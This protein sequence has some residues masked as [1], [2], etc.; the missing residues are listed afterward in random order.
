MKTAA[1]SVSER[2][3]VKIWRSFLIVL[4]SPFV[5]LALEFF[6]KSAWPQPPPNFSRIL[7]TEQ[8][9]HKIL[10]PQA[11][12][13]NY[14]REF[15]V[16]I[17]ANQYGY[18]QGTWPGKPIPGKVVWLFGDSFTF[19]WGVE[20]QETFSARLNQAGFS[21]YDLGIPDDGWADYEYRFEWAKTHLP[22]PDLIVIASYDNDYAYLAKTIFK[23]DAAKK[24]IKVR[25]ILVK[26]Q[27]GRLLKRIS[28]HLGLTK[29]F[30]MYG[31]S[32]I[33]VRTAY[34]RDFSVHEK[35]YLDSKSGQITLFWV[36]HFIEEAKKISSN[37]ILVRIAPGYCN[38]LSW[39]KE[40]LSAL[41]KP[42]DHYDF[43]RLDQELKKISQKHSISYL[44]FVPITDLETKN[45]YYRYDLHLTKLGHEA[46]ALELLK[47]INL[48]KK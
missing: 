32:E 46:L 48:I 7:F 41:G 14:A 3:T 12:G 28:Y 17:Q 27:V 40:A 5:L 23:N 34:G 6:L 10:I 24:A 11:H 26:S 29:F 19:G 31:G 33:N 39:Q 30:S 44:K 13:T 36:E 35:N 20:A 43:N 37:C 18:R 42:P 16:D 45:Y 1:V 9:G 8:N 21:V 22:P 25:K 38:G 2:K 15:S 4:I 47:G